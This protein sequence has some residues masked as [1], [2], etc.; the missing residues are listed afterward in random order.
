MLPN[1]QQLGPF[2]WK[3][4]KQIPHTDN[5]K[6][7]GEQVGCHIRTKGVPT[8]E[9]EKKKLCYRCGTSIL[10]EVATRFCAGGERKSSADR[11]VSEPVFWLHDVTPWRF[12]NTSL[13]SPR[14]DFRAAKRREKP[15]GIQE[16]NQLV[17][18]QA[19]SRHSVAGDCLNLQAH[20]RP[21]Q[22]A[23]LCPLLQPF[24]SS[25]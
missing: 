10:P 18:R 24:K 14:P 12:L 16:S 11:K 3:T 21:W 4:N 19:I 17:G 7:N 13:V 22:T 9:R 25:D 6:Q 23:C 5:Q 2:T 20:V 1:E 15:Q 8:R